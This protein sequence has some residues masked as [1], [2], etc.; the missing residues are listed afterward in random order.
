[1]DDTEVRAA[2]DEQTGD[3]LADWEVPPG[4]VVGWNGSQVSREAVRWAALEAVAR[5]CSLTVVHAAGSYVDWFDPAMVPDASAL[6]VEV[7]MEGAR[8]ARQVVDASV[9]VVTHTSA[10]PAGAGCPPRSILIHPRAD[11]RSAR[12][13][14]VEASRRAQLVVVGDRGRGE[15]AAALLGSV[16][17]SV[18][19]HA[20]CPVVVV[21]DDGY[22]RAG[23]RH[24]VVVGVDGSPPATAA[25]G[26]AAEAADRANAPVHVRASWSTPVTPTYGPLMPPSPVREAEVAR[27]AAQRRADH[28]REGIR[29]T[30]PGLEVVVEVVEEHA[31][32]GLARAS[33]GAGLVVVGSRGRGAAR[34]LLLGSTSLE[35][36]H[37][38]SCP[39]AVVHAP[40]KH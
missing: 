4:V 35:L 7:A 14:L 12:Q 28:A 19:A 29:L 6:A 13:V 5:G 26:F 16:A 3:Q 34:G 20:R 21:R 36:L 33:D 18:V 24:A 30:H 8:F 39:L 37:R 1:M 23:P 27:A 31:A 25:V 17:M 32:T 15:L 10:G 38:T 9:P 40:A 2:H 11:L 22:R